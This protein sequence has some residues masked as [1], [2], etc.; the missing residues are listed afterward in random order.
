MS[1][2]SCNILT[3]QVKERNCPIIGFQGFALILNTFGGTAVW[4]W[5]LCQMPQTQTPNGVF[6]EILAPRVNSQRQ[7]DQIS[8]LNTI[9]ISLAD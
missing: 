4:I 9:E 6:L 5:N 7:R 2:N 3:T 1:S 8:T